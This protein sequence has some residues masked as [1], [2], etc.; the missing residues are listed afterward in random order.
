MGDYF[1]H[2]IDIGEKADSDKLPRIFYVN[3]FRKSDDGEWLWPGF[4]ENS[5]A[6]KWIFERIVG[7][8]E[9]VKTPIGYLPT[10]DAIDTAELEVAEENIKQL[11]VADT[12]EWL[13]EVERIEEHYSRFGDE[14]PQELNDE[15]VALKNRLQKVQGSST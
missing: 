9:A 6:I 2:W 12:Q 7:R 10:L 11:L 5:R 13:G 1:Q 14:L 3:W 8:A 4:G 15:L